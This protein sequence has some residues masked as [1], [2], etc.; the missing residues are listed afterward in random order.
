MY[1]WTTS[2]MSMTKPDGRKLELRNSAEHCDEADAQ[3]VGAKSSCTSILQTP[4]VVYWLLVL[5]T[6]PFVEAL[7]AILV[8]GGGTPSS[9]FS[10][11]R[12][13][14]LRTGGPTMCCP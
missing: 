13:A 6:T 14:T 8:L 1:E 3:E 11:T 5:E 2:D 4:V 9:S 10:T 7:I 12:S